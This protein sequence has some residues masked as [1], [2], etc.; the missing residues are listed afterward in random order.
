MTSTAVLQA[1]NEIG[2]SPLHEAANQG[3]AK[4]V[5]K[6]LQEGADASCRDK[7]SHHASAGATHAMRVAALPL[8][9]W[10]AEACQDLCQYLH[11]VLQSVMQ[12]SC[13]SLEAG[14]GQDA[15]NEAMVVL[16]LKWPQHDQAH[17]GCNTLDFCVSRIGLV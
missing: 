9:I 6:L 14:I 8:R 15:A 7:V 4:V 13:C 11:N 1:R 10:L 12:K 16:R 2:Q 17:G 3:H 5:E